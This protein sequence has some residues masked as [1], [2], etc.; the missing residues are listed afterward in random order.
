MWPFLPFTMSSY[1]KVVDSEN[2]ECPYDPSHAI[3]KNRFVTH[4]IE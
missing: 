3:P 1:P 2:Y 4:L